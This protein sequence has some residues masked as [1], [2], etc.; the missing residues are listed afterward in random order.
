MPASPAS[1][2]Y[3]PAF[4]SFLFFFFVAIVNTRPWRSELEELAKLV[5]DKKLP[6]WTLTG[7][8]ITLLNAAAASA[9]RNFTFG[10]C[11]RELQVTRRRLRRRC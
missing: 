11:G 1:R 10:A 7:K 9:T 3:Q 4:F 5:A 8:T 6:V 2:Q